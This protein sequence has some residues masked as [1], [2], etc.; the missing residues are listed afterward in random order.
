[1]TSPIYPAQLPILGEAALLA[2]MTETLTAASVGTT[3]SVCLEATDQSALIDGDNFQGICQ[4]L[5]NIGMFEQS[6]FVPSD[7]AK[8]AAKPSSSTLS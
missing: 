6:W 7:A 5:A 1:M 2:W 3:T 8:D 4:A